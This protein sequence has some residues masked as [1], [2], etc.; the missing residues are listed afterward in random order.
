RPG[1]AAA[2]RPRRPALRRDRHAAVVR[3]RRGTAAHRRGDRPVPPPARR[4]G[5]QAETAARRAA[6]LI[7]AVRTAGV[8]P[9][10]RGQDIAPRTRPML[11]WL[12]QNAVVAALLAG[13]VA[14]ACRV[15]RLRPAVR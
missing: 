9:A 8:K 2:A 10:A 12:A 4:A 7:P 6:G 5:G 1:A 3:P 14:L 13:I 15:G 11:W